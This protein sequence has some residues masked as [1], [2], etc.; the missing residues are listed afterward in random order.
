MSK[1]TDKLKRLSGGASQPIGFM[2]ASSP[3]KS[4]SMMLIAGIKGI[5]S[6]TA[7]LAVKEGA[8]GVLVY[9]DDL[10]SESQNLAHIAEAVGDIPWGVWLGEVVDED[11]PM[12]TEMGCDFLVLDTSASSSLLWEEGLGR[13]L[14]VSSSIPDSLAFTVSPLPVEAVLIEDGRQTVSIELVMAC[15]RLANLVRKPLVVLAPS[16]LGGRDLKALRE[17]GV[18]GVVVRLEEGY[19]GGRLSELYQAIASLPPSGRG[20]RLDAI[21][22]YQGG[23]TLEEEEE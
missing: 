20:R 23:V 19:Q 13:V 4:P 8:G 16:T 5:G 10:G 22:P 7:K 11:A 12:L 14:T 18:V 1:L 2:A 6:E 15:Q 3:E 21:L 17:V 9:V